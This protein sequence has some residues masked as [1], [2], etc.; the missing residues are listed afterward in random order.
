VTDVRGS[1]DFATTRWSVVVAA[2][3][4]TGGAARAALETLCCAYWYPLYADAR[5]RGASVHD[6]ADL[7]QSFF[8]ALLEKD[9]V[10]AA[11]PERGRFRAYLVTAFRHFA[12]HEREKAR[13]A[14]RGGGAVVSL[15]VAAAESRLSTELVD[16]MTPERAFER[17]FALTLLARALERVRTE[18]PDDADLLPFIGG[19]GEPRPYAEIAAARR[20]SEGAVKTAVHRL[21]ARWSDLVR[22]EV[23]DTVAADADVDDEIRHLMDVVGGG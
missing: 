9:W 14:K 4:P 23:R 16:A 17:R 12:A 7:V 13:A 5:R 10:A 15:D 8:A 3:G 20:T 6:A 21:R 11:D 18:R 19:P 2:G 1:P 22:A